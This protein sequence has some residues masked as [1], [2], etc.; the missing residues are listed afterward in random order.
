MSTP[1][2]PISTVSANLLVDRLEVEDVALGGRVLPFE[3]PVEGAEGAVLG[4]EVG[5]VDVAIDDVGDDALGVQPAADGVG[6]HAQADQV[7]GVEVVEGLLAGYRHVFSSTA[8][9]LWGQWS[10]DQLKSGGHWA[11][12]KPLGT[13]FAIPLKP[14]NGLNGHPPLYFRG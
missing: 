7:V 5:V 4:A 8:W 11:R 9:G 2:P 10:L 1:V 13:G 6:F 12:V 14:T 3:R